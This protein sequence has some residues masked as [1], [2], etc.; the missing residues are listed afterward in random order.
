MK[1]KIPITLGL[2][3]ISRIILAQG[4][5]GMPAANGVCIPPDSQTSPLHSSY[6]A[7]ENAQPTAR[8]SHWL[9]TWGAVAMDSSTGD[10]GVSVGKSS[11]RNALREAISRCKNYGATNCKIELAY[12]N[13]CAVVAWASDGGK[14][15]GGAAITQSG[16]SVEVAS[17]LALSACSKLRGGGECKIIYSDCTKP[18][19]VQ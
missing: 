5:G 6:G 11:K 17:Q 10:V 18:V 13:Q 3:A 2:F 19:L 14:A 8:Q 16:P 15:I 12:Q 1:F 9:L 7:Q 4:C